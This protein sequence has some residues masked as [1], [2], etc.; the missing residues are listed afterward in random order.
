MTRQPPAV[1]VK[2]G[3]SSILTFDPNTL[4]PTMTRLFSLCSILA[5]VTVSLAR[6]PIIPMHTGK[7]VLSGEGLG[8]CGITTTDK[9]LV[10]GVSQEY[11]DSY[12]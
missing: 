1:L 8:A 5:L 3:S 11:F 7:A 6:I 2:R 4:I 9:E 10:T 12:P